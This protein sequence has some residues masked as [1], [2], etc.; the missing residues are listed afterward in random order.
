MGCNF[1]ITGIFHVHPS[2]VSS[3]EQSPQSWHKRNLPSFV[4]RVSMIEDFPPAL[5]RRVASKG[6]GSSF[7]LLNR[8]V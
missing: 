2:C 8:I 5:Q 1:P 6:F 3:R 7:A 4:M